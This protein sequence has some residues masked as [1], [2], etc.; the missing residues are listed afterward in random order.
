MI[1]AEPTYLYTASIQHNFVP[2][3]VIHIVLLWFKLI[4]LSIWVSVADPGFDLGA[5]TLSTGEE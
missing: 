2:V 1:R 5:W 4:K 3:P